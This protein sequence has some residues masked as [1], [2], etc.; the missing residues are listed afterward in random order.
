MWPP[1]SKEDPEPSGKGGNNLNGVKD[2]DLDDI[3]GQ[4]GTSSKGGKLSNGDLHMDLDND[5]LM[6]PTPIRD[7]GVGF[8]NNFCR[9]AAI[10]IF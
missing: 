6:D 1:D 10:S 5:D 2:M 8:L 9:K 4:P 7:L 3:L